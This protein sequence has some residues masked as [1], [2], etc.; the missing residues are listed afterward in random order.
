MYIHL[1]KLKYSQFIINNKIIKNIIIRF[2][3]IT[4][5]LQIIYIILYLKNNNIDIDIIKTS[6]NLLEVIG[7]LDIIQY[8]LVI[9]IFV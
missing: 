9:N 5:K 2:I 3:F 4:F 7:G 6:Y 8:P 1:F